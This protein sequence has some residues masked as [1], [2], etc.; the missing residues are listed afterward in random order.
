MLGASSTQQELPAPLMERARA[1]WA[2][3]Q[4]S[5]N[6]ADNTRTVDARQHAAAL[7]ESPQ[8]QAANGELY[9]PRVLGTYRDSRWI[10]VGISVLAADA[11]GARRIRHPHVDAICNALVDAGDIAAGGG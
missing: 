9:E 6:E 4:A 5:H 3:D 7:V 10:P 1:L 11:E 2:S 8:W